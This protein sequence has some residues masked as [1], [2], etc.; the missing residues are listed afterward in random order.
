MCVIVATMARAKLP[1]KEIIQKCADHNKDGGGFM[2]VK[3]KRVHIHKGYS[4]AAK[5]FDDIMENVPETAPIVV[6]FRL[7][8]HGG[9]KAA[10]CHPFPIT[11]DFDKMCALDISCSY[12]VAHNGIFGYSKKDT[13]DY[14][15]TQHFIADTLCDVIRYIEVDIVRKLF[16]NA[17]G[18]NKLALLSAKGTLRLLGTFEKDGDV[19]FS[20]KY[21]DV[22]PV[23]YG[24]GYWNNREWDKCC[25]CHT[26]SWVS[27]DSRVCVKCT[28][29]AAK[30]ES[31]TKAV[32]KVEKI[33]GKCAICGGWGLLN[34][35]NKCVICASCKMRKGKCS[36]CKEQDTYVYTYNGLCYDC[37]ALDL[38]T[39]GT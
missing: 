14:S 17:L 38:T 15:D 28:Q 19:W 30:T 21:W 2:Y 20:N 1:S 26:R 13:G 34:L 33:Y 5:M 36:L 4:D 9:V 10:L 22:K 11:K 25:I 7:A 24:G 39:G 37:D 8:T 12:G 18:T 23:V 35:A 32:T 27:L 29:E 3:D 16:L 31:S 6:H